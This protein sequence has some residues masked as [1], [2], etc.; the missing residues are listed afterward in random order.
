[1]SSYSSGF[2]SAVCVE[3]YLSVDH[4]PRSK[5]MLKIVWGAEDTA[6]RAIIIISTHGKKNLHAT[7]TFLETLHTQPKI[8]VKT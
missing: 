1:M 5:Q 2:M 3:L 7:P 4:S 6:V 8:Y